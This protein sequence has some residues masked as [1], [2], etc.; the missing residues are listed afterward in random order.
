MSLSKPLTDKQYAECFNAFKKVST[1]W[2][3]M[4]HW[5]D[6][7]LLPLMAGRNSARI[8]SIGSGTGDFD[9]TLM[10]LLKEEIPGLDYT[11]LDPNTEH[12]QI[13][14]SRYEESGLRLSAFQ[15]IPEPFGDGDL[16]GGFDL[17]HMTHCLYYITDRKDAILNAY[18]LLN[19]GGVLLIFHQ[20][21]VG[22]NE[23]QKAFMRR[24][25]GD[26]KEMFSAH[27]ILRIFAELGIR[28]NF[29]ILISDIDVTDCIAEN[30]N[31]RKL[32][33]FFLESDLDGLDRP[34][35]DEIIETLKSICR[36][37]G[38]RYFLF[39]P[40]GIFWIRKDDV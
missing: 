18:N 40:C 7:E 4:D 10:R 20:T 26:E 38:G 6:K 32:L 17:I 29:D 1:E 39:H 28:F 25:K 22:I 3:A 35:R 12:N 23:I 13:F 30:D 21:A 24:A 33:N 16:R 27:D 31:G 8:L 14:S 36:I 34:L 19:P 5:L 9:L 37:E 2:A 15:I 11:A